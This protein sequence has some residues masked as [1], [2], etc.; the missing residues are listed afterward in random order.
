M[1]ILYW[2]QKE[3]GDGANSEQLQA[4][5]RTVEIEHTDVSSSTNHIVVLSYP[6]AF[7]SPRCGRKKVNCLNKLLLS[8]RTF[9]DNE[10]VLGPAQWCSS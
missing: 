3:M 1:E 10:N 4:S 5:L 7:F 2:Q 8:S 9:C 6:A